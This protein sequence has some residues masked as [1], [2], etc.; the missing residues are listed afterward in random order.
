MRIP[1][2]ILVLSPH[3]DDGEVAAGGTIARHAKQGGEVHYVAFSSAERSLPKGMP[4]ETTR[5]EC[6]AATKALGV[7]KENVRIYD[8]D[9]R[10]FPQRR[11]E[12]LE[13]LIELREELKPELVLVTSSSDVHQ[14]HQTIH[15]EAIRAFKTSASLWGY[16]HPWNNLSFDF[17]V[18]VSLDERDVQAKLRAM[19]CYKSQFN[20]AYFDPEYVRGLLR[21][22]GTQ[23]NFRYAEAF[24]LIRALIH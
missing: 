6:L 10:S 11:Q 15:W 3:T 2:R 9:V 14:D 21:V 8:Y 12:I 19:K 7:P 20:R 16:E 1:E 5:N 4:R 13:G 17:D 23:A 24:E 22:H 18:L